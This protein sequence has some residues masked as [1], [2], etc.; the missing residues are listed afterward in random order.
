MLLEVQ[1][2]DWVAP[3]IGPL[4]R[5]ALHGKSANHSQWS[6]LRQRQKEKEE[7]DKEGEKEEEKRGE[8]QRE[9]LGPHNPF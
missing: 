2:K 9:R 8:R 7:E 6:H 4:V 5:E 1:V 3:G